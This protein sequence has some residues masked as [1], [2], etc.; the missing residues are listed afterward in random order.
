MAAEAAGAATMV[1][2]QVMATAIADRSLMWT[3]PGTANRSGREAPPPGPR[4]TT[5]WGIDAR[6]G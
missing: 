1:A 6:H 5:G 4:T 3:F 2:A